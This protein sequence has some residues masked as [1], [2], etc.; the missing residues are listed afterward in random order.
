MLNRSIEGLLIKNLNGFGS[1]I[2]RIL[3]GDEVPNNAQPKILY[4]SKLLNP[5]LLVDSKHSFSISR[6]KTLEF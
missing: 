5:I 6:S 1:N 4:K 2:E 3:R